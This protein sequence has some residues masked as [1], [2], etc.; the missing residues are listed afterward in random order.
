MHTIEKLISIYDSYFMLQLHTECVHGP[1][2][3][4]AND[5]S[6][7]KRVFLEHVGGYRLG[8]CQGARKCSIIIDNMCQ[9]MRSSLCR[10]TLTFSGNY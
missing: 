3:G 5:I 9:T 4:E 1:E 6:C 2:K 8:V 7:L 10:D